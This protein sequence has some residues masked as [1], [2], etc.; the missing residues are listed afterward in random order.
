MGLLKEE[1]KLLVEY[2]LKKAKETFAEIE[3]LIKV[4]TER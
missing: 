4:C 3:N 1:R 2:R